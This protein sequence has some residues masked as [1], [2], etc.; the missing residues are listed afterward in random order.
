MAVIK[1]NFNPRHLK[2]GDVI[3]MFDPLVHVV[4]WTNED[5]PDAPDAERDVIRKLATEIV[6]RGCSVEQPRLVI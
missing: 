2:L 4:V 3:K 6:R 1:N 5:D